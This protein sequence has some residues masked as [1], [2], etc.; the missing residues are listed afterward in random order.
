MLPTP[1]QSL[2][3]IVPNALMEHTRE[4]MRNAFSVIIPKRIITLKFDR[5]NVL[6]HISQLYNKIKKGKNSSAVVITTPEAIKSLALKFVECISSMEHVHPL[7]KIPEYYLIPHDTLPVVK[8]V[9]EVRNDLENN[10]KVASKCSK[11]INIWKSGI[12]LLDEVLH[13]RF[14]NVS[15]S[16]CFNL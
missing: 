2:T 8:S 13:I 10:F 12:A 1:S 5:S 15:L 16:I 6:S 4:V 11:I 7:L 14:Q 9:F 3:L